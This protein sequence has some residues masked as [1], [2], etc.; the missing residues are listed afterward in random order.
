[1][2]RDNDQWVRKWF[3]AAACDWPCPAFA[4][5]VLYIPGPIGA[6]VTEH[7]ASV[8]GV[9]LK[10]ATRFLTD[11]GRANFIQRR[12]FRRYCGAVASGSARPLS[13]IS[14]AET[15]NGRPYLREQPHVW[16]SFSSCRLG[17]LGGWSSTHA[18]GLDLEDQDCA[19]E[20]S[21]LARSYFT[22][23]EARAVDE[24]GPTQLRTFLQLWSL[25]E[26]ALKSIDQGLPFG[27]DK[28]AFKLHGHPRVLEA[29]GDHGGPEGFSAHLFDHAA[30]SAAMVFRTL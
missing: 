25:K 5:R 14:F 2:T 27:L 18:I 17:F 16:F 4:D 3:D 6:E 23:S 8:L 12:A 1:M 24:A 20:A 22:R 29:P 26:A 19:I 15:E 21:E 7:C 28:F 13:Q 9:E 11:P 10:R 30:V